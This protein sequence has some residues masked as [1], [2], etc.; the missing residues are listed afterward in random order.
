MAGARAPNSAEEKVEMVY[1]SDGVGR[2]S[3]RNRI[4]GLVLKVW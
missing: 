1:N 3:C 4:R 2:C